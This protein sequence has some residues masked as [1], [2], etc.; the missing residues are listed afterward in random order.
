MPALY[1][2]PI[3]DWLSS[4]VPG[5]NVVM[6]LVVDRNGF[7]VWGTRRMRCALGRSG[8]AAAKREGDGATPVGSFAMRQLLYRPDRETLPETA[9]P[10]QTLEPDGGWCDAPDDRA[11]NRLVLLPYPTSAE[12]LWRDD[13]LYD[14]IV[15]L[16]YNDDPVVP[17]RGSAIFLHLARP[18]FGPTEGCVALNREDLLAVITGADPA[19]RVIVTG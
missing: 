16:G 10:C 19:S 1:D 12:T 9:L 5:Q 2:A 4:R 7:A 11:Y 13:P 3:A 6:D 17:G 18:D 14:L 8:I 15:V